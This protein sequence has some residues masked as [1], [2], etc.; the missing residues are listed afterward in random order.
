MAWQNLAEEIG[1]LFTVDAT[2][3]TV[4]AGLARKSFSIMRRVGRRE[5]EARQ[6]RDAA[7]DNAY[8]TAYWA[9]NPDKWRATLDRGNAA[10]R[11]KRAARGLKK[12]RPPPMTPKQVA[13]A[14][15][16]ELPIWH[17]ANILKVTKHAVMYHRRKAGLLS[18]QAKGA[19][20]ADVVDR[21]A[22]GG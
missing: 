21:S 20:D 12:T 4:I 13:F 19:R 11:A 2:E 16:S 15:A 6:A 10:K 17:V 18:S 8:R 7:R 3:R 1:E 5:R 14:V 9:A 22:Q